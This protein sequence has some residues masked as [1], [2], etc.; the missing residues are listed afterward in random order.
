VLDITKA[1]SPTSDQRAAITDLVQDLETEFGAPPLNDA[2]LI[3]L[4]SDEFEHWIVSDGSRL[5]GYAQLDRASTSAE[6]AAGPNVAAELLTAVV[7]E[8]PGALVWA[9]GQRSPVGAAAKSLGYPAIRTLW[10]L[11]RP[12]TNLDPIPAHEVTLRAFRVGSDE[13]AW[14]ELNS[15]AFVDHDEQ[16]DWTMADLTARE[17]EPWFDPAGFLMAERDDQLLGFHWT[18]VH[19]GGIG[20]VYVLAVAPA[21]Q[22]LHLGQVLLAAGLHHLAEAG[23]HTVLLYVDDDNPAAMALYLRR[24]FERY[25]VDIQYRV[26]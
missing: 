13:A 18:K 4:E 19:P 16:G 23:L 1:A 20:E 21:A 9:H 12:L 25:D 7:E 10:Q 3:G 2:A 8:I 26:G 17:A 24:G 22:G 11:R 14:L 6:I 5:V 15:A